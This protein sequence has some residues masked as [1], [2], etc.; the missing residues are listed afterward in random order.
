M[1]HKNFSRNANY[2]QNILTGR[3]DSTEC[4]NNIF[5]RTINIKVR[6]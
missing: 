2:I 4:K 3:R 1:E 6:R 5:Y